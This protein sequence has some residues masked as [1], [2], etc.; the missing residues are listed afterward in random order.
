[1][2]F[3]SN[4]SHEAFGTDDGWGFNIIHSDTITRCQREIYF[5]I[6]CM[7]ESIFDKHFDELLH[8]SSIW[9]MIEKAKIIKLLFVSKFD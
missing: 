7:I 2:Y 6:D 1:M 5:N 8:K 9:M 4:E 3:D